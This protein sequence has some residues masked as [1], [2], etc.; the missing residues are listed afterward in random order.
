MDASGFHLAPKD[1][2]GQALFEEFLERMRLLD[3]SRNSR[4]PE[5]PVSIP[6]SEPA[7]KSVLPPSPFLKKNARWTGPVAAPTTGTG[8]TLSQLLTL[9]LGNI[10]QG[11]KKATPAT[12]DRKYAVELL[13]ETVGNLSITDLT[14]HDAIAFADL[15]STWPKLKH[16]YHD[17]RDL[18][19]LDVAEIA[20]R[21]KLPAI[22]VGTQR[23]HIL[24]INAFMNWAIKVGEL[25]ENPFRYLDGARY[26][27]DEKGRLLDKK[28]PFS[29]ADLAAI[30]DSSHMRSHA[31]PHKYWLPLIAYFTGMRVNEI[32]QL[33]IDN[34]TLK[35]YLDEEGVE[36][37]IL[38]FDIS[39]HYE[40][41]S[42]KSGYGIRDIPI[43]KAILELGFETYLEEVRASGS[44]LLFPGIPW[45]EGGPGRCVS[46]WFNGTH[47]RVTCGITSAR[48]T[49]HCFR[50]NLAT[51]MERCH[52]PKSIARAINGHSPG[53]DL[54]DKVYVA[55]ATPLECQRVLDNLPFP[56]LDL[57]PYEP[58]RFSHYLTQTA[59]ERGREKRMR[60]AGKPYRRPLGPRP[61]Q[62]AVVSKPSALG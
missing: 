55:R 27:R 13:V 61:K 25:S 15:L 45:A 35:P 33:Y 50:H 8:K 58:G 22:S 31:A 5:V 26:T 7:S 62:R 12:R 52:V 53:E 9:H 48:K 38:V 60:D 19:A 16:S 4:A 46:Q 29:H 24:E 10:R 6:C 44:R 57:L 37:N 14:P 56:K 1:P 47:L 49:L 40:G 2:E 51:L 42:V 30:F 23:K 20:K 17:L 11:A 36:H 18:P 43:P 28:D 39:T 59:V 32:A 34:V 3:E 41:Q 54:E 21:R